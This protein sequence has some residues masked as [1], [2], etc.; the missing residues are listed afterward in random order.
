MK[1]DLNICHQAHHD[2]SLMSVL[3]TLG[4]VLRIKDNK[5]VTVLHGVAL[6]KSHDGSNKKDVDAEKKTSIRVIEIETRFRR[7]CKTIY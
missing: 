7:G 4:P 6:K 1:V 2:R 5:R 3:K